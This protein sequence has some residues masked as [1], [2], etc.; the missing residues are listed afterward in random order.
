MKIALPVPIPVVSS[1]PSLKGWPR[2]VDTYLVTTLHGPLVRG[3]VEEVDDTIKRPLSAGA[4]SGALDWTLSRAI[5]R[6]G[7]SP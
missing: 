7:H 6:G 5:Q 1:E 3:A 2:C 4:L